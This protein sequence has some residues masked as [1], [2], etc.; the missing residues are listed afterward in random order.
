M[1]PLNIY[2]A[3]VS[4]GGPAIKEEIIIQV[5]EQQNIRF[6]ELAQLQKEVERGLEASVRLGFVDRQGQIYKLKMKMPA[7][8]CNQGKALHSKAVSD[9]LKDGKSQGRTTSNSSCSG[10]SDLGKI[11]DQ[12]R[13]LLD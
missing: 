5:A 12:E 10:S 6:N 3:F 1:K 7:A 2:G 8:S 13:Q 9:P 4:L 11:C